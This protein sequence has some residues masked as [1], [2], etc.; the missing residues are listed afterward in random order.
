MKHLVAIATIILGLPLFL[1]L[2][3]GD[4]EAATLNLD[5]AGLLANVPPQYATYVQEAGGICPGVSPSVIAAQI[6]TE[7][8]WNPDAHSPAGA[9]GISQFMPG[10]WTS[11]G[12]D[13]NDDGRIDVFDPADAIISQGHYMCGLYGQV[14]RIFGRE[15][16]EFTLAAYNAGLGNVQSWAGIPPFP[17]T[18]NYVDQVITLAS[19]TYSETITAAS[20]DVAVVIEWAQARVGLPYRGGRAGPGC[21][22]SGPNCYDC[23]GL[24]KVAYEQIGVDL[25][26]SVPGNPSRI[27][28][29]EYAMYSYA[30]GTHVP[31]DQ[32]QPGDLVFFQSK[33]VNPD[34]DYITHVGIYIGG[35]KIIDSI[36]GGGVGVRDLDYYRSSET[37]LDKV[38]R[39]GNP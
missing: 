12:V 13:G 37:I 17:E 15:S 1:I 30:G 7:S 23:C 38:V 24:V 19:T 4:E 20:G 3:L 35:G 28:K 11:M 29:C 34:Y 32:V 6:H 14:E 8:G 16:I 9:Q 5:E 10:T 39:I 26:M 22:S 31:L 2:V 27:A 33:S 36:P 21:G 25:P 18:Q